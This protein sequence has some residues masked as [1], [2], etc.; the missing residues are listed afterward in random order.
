MSSQ[1]I[2]K[3]RSASKNERRYIMRHALGWYRSLVISGLYTL[4]DD[5]AFDTT[6]ISSYLPA[7]KRCIDSH[8]ILSTAIE[9]ESTEAPT[10]VRPPELDLRNHIKILESRFPDDPSPDE[11][12]LLK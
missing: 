7:V 12:D 8:P 9:G 11:L 4:E 3:L 5:T 2:V 1:A 10:F 6:S